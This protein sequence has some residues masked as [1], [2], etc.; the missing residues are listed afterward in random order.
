MLQ[1]LGESS[2]GVRREDTEENGNLSLRKNRQKK[3]NFKSKNRK[4]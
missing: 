4:S 2:Q 1:L 3:Y